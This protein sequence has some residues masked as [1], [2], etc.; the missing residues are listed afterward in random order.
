[1]K[2]KKWEFLSPSERK[3][4]KRFKNLSGEEYAD[5]ILSDMSETE[6]RGGRASG[7]PN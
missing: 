1:M 2:D 7:E 5:L 3:H 4:L 6:L